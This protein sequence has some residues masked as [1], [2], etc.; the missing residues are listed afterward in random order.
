MRPWTIR[1][2]CY[3][4]TSGTNQPV[5]KHMHQK[6]DDLIGKPDYKILLNTQAASCTKTHY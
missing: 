6:H 5:T 2:T 3:L 1:P 4:K